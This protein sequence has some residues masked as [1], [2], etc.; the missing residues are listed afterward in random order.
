MTFIV[1]EDHNV[2]RIYLTKIDITDIETAIA[3]R[4]SKR[5]LQRIYQARSH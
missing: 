5:K 3:T 2:S 4:V 1:T